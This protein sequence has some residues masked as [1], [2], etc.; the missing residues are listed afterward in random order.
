MPAAIKRLRDVVKDP[1][2]FAPVIDNLAKVIQ[3]LHV[4]KPAEIV[5]VTAGQEEPALFPR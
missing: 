2:N 5:I 3:S 1:R 4:N